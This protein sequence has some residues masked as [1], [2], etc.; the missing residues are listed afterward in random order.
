MP[1]QMMMQT[2]KRQTATSVASC[3]QNL[4]LQYLSQTVDNWPRDSPCSE[5]FFPGGAATEGLA[6]TVVEVSSA[7]ATCSSSKEDGA[8]RLVPNT[9]LINP[10]VHRQDKRMGVDTLPRQNNKTN[11]LGLV[12]YHKV[13]T[14]V[15]CWN[16]SY[17][18]WCRQSKQKLQRQAWWTP[19]L[20]RRSVQTNKHMCR[21]NS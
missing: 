11:G 12:T 14:P 20:P 16:R 5:N 10:A 1:P 13:R 4:C 8:G 18:I 21:G 3:P 15:A 6:L 7:S 17:R 9:C 2:M 19:H